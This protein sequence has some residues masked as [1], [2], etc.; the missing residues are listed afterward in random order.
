MQGLAVPLYR[1]SPLAG[2]SI[3][4]WGEE[5]VV[6][7]ALSNDTHRVADA[8]GRILEALATAPS[9]SARDLEERCTLDAD[10]VQDA[11]ATLGDL[12]FVVPC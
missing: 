1:L 12:D 10:V 8:A 2:L 4:R 5:C 11:L 7:H 3:R 6:Y 9:L